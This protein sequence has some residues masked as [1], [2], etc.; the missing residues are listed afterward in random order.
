MCERRANFWDLFISAHDTWDQHFTRCV[1]IFVFSVWRYS[2]NN[3]TSSVKYV[4]PLLC[5]TLG[6]CGLNSTALCMASTAFISAVLNPRLDAASGENL[7][8]EERT[9][10]KM[11]VCV[12][13]GGI[14][15]CVRMWIIEC[16]KV[17]TCACRQA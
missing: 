3:A 10:S 7:H 2:S 11:G 5:L 6:T 13:G 4:A 12:C 17:S 9:L 1:Y 16:M 8:G 14:S 15:V